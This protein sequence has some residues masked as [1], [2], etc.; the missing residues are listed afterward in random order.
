MLSNRK[1]GAVQKIW[2][3]PLDYFLPA[4]LI[5]AA[6]LLRLNLLNY[7]MG[8]RSLGGHPLRGK[9]LSV[10]YHLQASPCM[11]TAERRYAGIYEGVSKPCVMIYLFIHNIHYIVYTFYFLTQLLEPPPPSPPNTQFS[12]QTLPPKFE[13][14]GIL[15]FI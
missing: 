1:Y 14:N 13:E 5:Q 4:G 3:S 7:Q 9:N 10:P 11:C 8:M 12:F 2:E 6:S 15:A